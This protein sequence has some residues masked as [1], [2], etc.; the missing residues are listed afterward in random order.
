M[1]INKNTNGSISIFLDAAN[2]W[3]IDYDSSLSDNSSVRSSVGLGV[4]W[5]TPVGPLSFSFAQPLSKQDS[6]I[7]EKFRFNLGTSF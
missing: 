4:N 7:V 1:T 3:G 6:D 2:V 5:S